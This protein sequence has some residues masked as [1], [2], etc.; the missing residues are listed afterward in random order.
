MNRSFIATGL[1]VLG[2]FFSSGAYADLQGR[3]L[4]RRGV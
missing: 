2:T 1:I 4:Q 3:L